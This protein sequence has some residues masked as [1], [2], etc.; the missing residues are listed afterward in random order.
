MQCHIGLLLNLLEQR[1]L[2]DSVFNNVSQ[3]RLRHLIGF[4]FNPRK[5]I[6]LPHFH[7]D[8]GRSAARFN[9]RPSIKITQHNLT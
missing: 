2:N 8:V 4:K 5:T 6:L 1:Q 7:R 3:I 9:A